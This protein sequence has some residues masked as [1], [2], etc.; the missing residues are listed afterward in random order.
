MYPIT[1]AV[2][3]LFEAE[4][5]QILRVSFDTTQ[6]FENLS[7]Y[8]NNNNLV[9]QTGNGQD[10]E[11]YTGQ[12]KVFDS[13][14]TS[15]IMLYAGN[16]LVYA[17]LSD[18]VPVHVEITDTNVMQGG[19]SIDRYACNSSKIE[20]GTAIASELKLKLNNA[21]GK[22][23]SIKFE[24]A[25]LFVEI[26]IADWTQDDPEIT[27]IPCGHYI[28]DKQP[29]TADVISISALDRMQLLDRAQPSLMPWTTDTDAVMTDN[30]G[31]EIDFNVF[32]RFPNTIQGIIN[33]VCDTCGVTLA[34]SIASLPNATLNL[35]YMPQ[36]QQQVT[37]RNLIQWCAGIMG[38]NAWFDW[39]GELRFSW[40]NNVTD[41][42]STQS[43][44]YSSD[45]QENSITLT[46][47]QYTNA[48]NVVV[49]SG[50]SDYAIDLKDNFLVGPFIAEV[51]PVL[52]NALVGF[53][54]RPFSASVIN[55]PYLWP[56]DV[57]TFT[58]KYENTYPSVLT[59]VN[60]GINCTT[61]LKS[62]G[63]TEQTNRGVTSTQLT[64]EQAQLINEAGN[65][66]QELSDSLDQEGIFNRLTNNGE[67]Q[68]IYMQDGKLYIN[69]TYARA[70]T[71]VLGGLGN[72]NGVLQM[73]D[74]SGNIIG[75]WD[76]GGMSASGAFSTKSTDEFGHTRETIINDGS[77]EIYYNGSMVAS[78][79]TDEVY[80]GVVINGDYI[81][82]SSAGMIT[83]EAENEFRIIAPELAVHQTESDLP[84]YGYTGTITYKD[85]NGVN[86]SLE[87]I[88]GICIG[89]S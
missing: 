65:G 80:N 40:F 7:L 60:F 12:T 25:D 77:I 39:N 18:G 61:A 79:E 3:A 67:A 2:K 35:P 8:D 64:P 17:N 44:R 62:V 43:N 73:M 10:I 82:L 13:D 46:G 32:I 71:L 27:W 9:Y 34:E 89:N 78:I 74:A 63:E 72:Q 52:R 33:E 84:A 48:Q 59:N 42:V 11:L 41:Y 81:R 45:Y 21:D 66:V 36:V 28:P 86:Q 31:T 29:R 1:S 50:T 23:N 87:F 75:Y 68:G 70:G 51:L 56:M 69:L 38:T 24:G 49:V 76:N 30:S 54:Y 85:E 6:M 58:D 4:E 5:K 55:A 57:V 15:V 83:C 19:F 88:N 47:I 53:S 37:Y 20:V 16:D 26:G 14:D 22:Y